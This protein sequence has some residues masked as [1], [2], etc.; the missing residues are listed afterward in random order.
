MEREGR[1][2]GAWCTRLKTRDARVGEA[3]IALVPAV[4]AVVLDIVGALVLVVVVVILLVL[5]LVEEDVLGLRSS[6]TAR[7]GGRRRTRGSG[8][9]LLLVEVLVAW[10]GWLT[11]AD[12]N[13]HNNTDG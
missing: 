1:S 13:N 6:G 10:R 8:N 2:G 5:L 12:N 11:G 4:L 3:D 9:L 7:A